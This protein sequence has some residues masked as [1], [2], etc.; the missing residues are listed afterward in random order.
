M[1]NPTI[2]LSVQSVYSELQEKEQAYRHDANEL[3]ALQ[4]TGKIDTWQYSRTLLLLA[5][6][7]QLL[8]I[9]KQQAYN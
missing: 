5:E 1:T 6:E 8:L 2:R 9:R 4:F 7:E 3:F